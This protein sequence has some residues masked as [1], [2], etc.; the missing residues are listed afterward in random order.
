MDSPP[1]ALWRIYGFDLSDRYPVV[2]SLQLHLPN[3]HMVSFHRRQGIRQV[4]DRPGADKSMLTTYS[5]KNRTDEIARGILY[6]DICEFYT[7]QA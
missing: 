6:R 7:W 4:L 2:L 3:M 5:M 1:E